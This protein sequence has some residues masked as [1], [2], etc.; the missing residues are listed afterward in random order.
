MLDKA[1]II[2]GNMQLS[3]TK[4]SGVL[5]YMAIVRQGIVGVMAEFLL[6]HFDQL[7]LVE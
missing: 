7:Y 5:V 3:V 2:G 4:L 6:A 1:T